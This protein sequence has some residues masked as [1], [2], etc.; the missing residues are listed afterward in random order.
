MSLQ[1]SGAIKMS[2]MN[3]LFGAPNGTP[4]SSYLYRGGGYSAFYDPSNVLIPASGPISFS[5]MYGAR[6]NYFHQNSTAVSVLGG[7][8]IAPWG[9]SP[10]GGDTTALW[11]WNSAGAATT[12]PIGPWIHFYKV[13]TADSTFTATLYVMDDNA[14]YVFLNGKL[15]SPTD[16]GGGWGGQGASCTF[17]VQQGINLLDIYSY[18]LGGPGG[19]IAAMYNGASLVLHTDSTWTAYQTSINNTNCHVIFGCRRINP[20]YTGPILTIR[21]SSDGAISDFYS[22]FMQ[23][24]L[25]TAIN[26]GG[27]SLTAWLNGATGYVY[28]WYDQTGN[29]NHALNTSNNTTQPNMAIFNGRWVIQFQNANA[30]LL[31]ITTGIQPNTIFCH[32][33]NTNTS[34]ATILSTLYDYEQRFGGGNGV[35]VLGD[36]NGGDW[37]YMGTLN[38][39]TNYS[40]N[41]GV[42]STSVLLNAWNYLTLSLTTPQWITSQTSGFS[43]S[44][45]RIGY[46][47]AN[48]VR[49]MNGYMTEMICHNTPMGIT[50]ITNFYHNRFF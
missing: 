1:T 45:S 38:G 25:T 31:T 17:T 6:K 36:T 20:L 29:G 7:Y 32:Y 8:T 2:E 11:I 18:N 35:T 34:Y 15:M 33:Y 47:G 41:N 26:G 39:G 30:T 44:F 13:F 12:T 10:P 42:S 28:R 19:M 5:S 46:D 16:F 43:S 23:S 24:Y 27:S 22:D 21:R 4:M 40:Y 9:Y 49:S 37:Y 48:Y 14:G 50:D 3:A